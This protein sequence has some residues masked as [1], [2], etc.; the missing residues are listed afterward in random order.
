M[1]DCLAL[2]WH[3]DFYSKFSLDRHCEWRNT[4]WFSGRIWVR[5]RHA[6]E[7]GGYPIAADRGSEGG[8]PLL[9]I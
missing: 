6:W 2:T 1:V 9:C 5:H 7:F 8:A 4:A 3:S